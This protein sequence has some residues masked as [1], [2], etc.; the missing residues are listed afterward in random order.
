MALALSSAIPVGTLLRVSAQVPGTQGIHV[1][2]VVVWTREVNG[3]ARVGLRFLTLKPDALA[4]VNDYVA[5]AA[6]A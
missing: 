5:A 3:E 4:A 2:A 6:A 1:T